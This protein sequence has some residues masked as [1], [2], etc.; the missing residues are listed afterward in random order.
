MG[1]RKKSKNK[2]VGFDGENCP[3]C[4]QPTLIMEHTKITERH[5]RQPFYYKRWFRCT[6]KGCKTD[7][8]MLPQYR[9]FR[10]PKIE[11]WYRKKE[12]DGPIWKGKRSE[13]VISE[14]FDEMLAVGT[15][16]WE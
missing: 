5:H 15:P 7:L 13:P 10:H 11:E 12:Q 16:P 14:D 3:R 6:T 1:K 9:V 2:I 8:I 4:G